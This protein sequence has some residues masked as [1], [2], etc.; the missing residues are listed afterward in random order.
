MIVARQFTAWMIPGEDPSRR[1]RCDGLLSSAQP[2]WFRLGVPMNIWRRYRQA[3][4]FIPFPHGTDFFSGGIPGNKLPGYDHLVPPGQR[5]PTA[6]H[7]LYGFE[8][9]LPDVASRSFRRR[10]EVGR[11]TTSTRTIYLGPHRAARAARLD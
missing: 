6:F 11:T 2:W 4:P 3:Q 7:E 1:V 9:S 10:G 8:N 5:P